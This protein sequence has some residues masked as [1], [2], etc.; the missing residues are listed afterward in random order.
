LNVAAA[1][2]PESQCRQL[3]RINRAKSIQMNL[4]LNQTRPNFILCKHDFPGIKNFEMKYS[5][6]VF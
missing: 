1:R 2:G 5:C 4:N 6:E 3:N